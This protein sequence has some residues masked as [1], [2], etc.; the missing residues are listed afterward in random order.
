MTDQER[1]QLRAFFE[2]KDEN[3]ISNREKVQQN[4]RILRRLATTDKSKSVEEAERSALEGEFPLGVVQ[5]G[6]KLIGFGI[7]ILNEDIYPL[8]RFEIFFRDCGLMG[9]LDLSHCR[10]LLF[11]DVYRNQIDAVHV[12]DTPA[13]RILG[14]QDNCLEHLDVAGAPGCLG[15]DVGKNR[16]RELDVSE[17]GD[18]VELYINDNR[19]EKV[20][21]TRNPKLK[22]FYCHNNYLIELDTRAN[23][24]LRHLN[25]T[26]NPMKRI[27]TLAPQ[28]ET[29]LPLILTA[30]D[31]GTVGLRYNPIYNAQWKETG[32]W[33]QAYYAYPDPGCDFDGWYDEDGICRNDE[34]V[35]EDRYGESRCLTA[36]FRKQQK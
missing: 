21:L 23:P 3:G 15:I 36:R 19:I 2:V 11:V 4:Q 26:G 16:L 7:H 5:E 34:A 17:N 6:E 9:E 8:Q 32:Q 28:R 10:D 18:L 20:D 22:Y 25:A 33:Q 24:L 14:L 12:E 29:A 27:R 13:L 35:W 31:G 1:E 30:E